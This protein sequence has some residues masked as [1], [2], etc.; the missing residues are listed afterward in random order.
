MFCFRPTLL[1]LFNLAY[2]NKYQLPT[3]IL[4]T[5][6]TF[7]LRLQIEVNIWW[8]REGRGQ[9]RQEGRELEEGEPHGHNNDEVDDEDE[10]DDGEVDNGNEIV[11]SNFNS[12]AP[13]A[14]GEGELTED[15]DEE[16]NSDEE[17]QQ[18][19]RSQPIPLIV[20]VEVRH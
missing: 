19:E 18:Q 13:L 14:E 1:Q 10:T 9:P 11:P 12:I 6:L 16:G 3:L 7:G 15:E 5:F 2:N 17:Q 8:E 4:V 20:Q